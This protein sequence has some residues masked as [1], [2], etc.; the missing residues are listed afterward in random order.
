MKMKEELPPEPSM[1]LGERAA[2][3]AEMA[4]D[5]AAR[6]ERVDS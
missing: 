2:R 3:A 4:A 5:A 1:S 6:G